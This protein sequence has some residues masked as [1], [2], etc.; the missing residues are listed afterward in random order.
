MIGRRE[1]EGGT[2]EESLEL[3]PTPGTA[4]KDG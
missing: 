4:R 2:Q 3:W 1:V